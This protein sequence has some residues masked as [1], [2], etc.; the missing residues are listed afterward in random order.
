MS[1][2]PL[3][4]A[5]AILLALAS[6]VPARALESALSLKDVYARTVEQQVQPTPEDLQNYID[7]MISTLVSNN[8]S[9]LPSQYILLVDR[10]PKVQVAMLFWLDQQGQYQ[11]IGA[12][13]VSTGRSPGFEHFETPTGVYAH[14][15]ANLDYRAEGSKNSKGVRG[16]GI[17][18]RRVFD[19]GWQK[20]KKGWGDKIIADMRMQMHATDPGLLESRLGT[21]QS[22][23]CVRIPGTLNFLLDRYAVLDADYLQAVAEGKKFWVLDKNREDNPWA[24]RYMVIVDSGKEQKP[25][26]AAYIPAPAPTARKQVKPA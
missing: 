18:G 22:K 17:K 9:N 16:Y 15:L 3:K 13:P 1:L 12:S 6:T 7:Q 23:G 10:N 25:E 4:P 5:L 14:S 8:I 2:F 11:L 20:A 26:W 21:V 24:G 19:F